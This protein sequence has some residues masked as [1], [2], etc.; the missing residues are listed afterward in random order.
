MELTSRGNRIIKEYRRLNSDAKYRRQSG[1]FVAEGARLCEDAVRSGVVMETALITAR[2]RAQYPQITAA[3]ESAAL[4]AFEISDSM[5]DYLSDTETPQGV[6]G[7]C[8]IPA[9]EGLLKT[10]GRYAAFEQIQDPGNLGTMIRTAEAFGLDGVLLSS[11]CC[12]PYSP[13]VLRSSM[14]GVFRLPLIPVGNLAA[15]LPSLHENGI[16][17]YACVVDNDAMAVQT[18]EFQ[19]GTVCVIGNEGNGLLPETVDACLKRITIPMAG[20]AESLNASMAAGIVFWEMVRGYAY[21]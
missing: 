6:F 5:A 18:V 17:S 10:G 12:D 8:R 14:G 9:F 11:G 13:K 3:V 4:Q 19:G 1:L 20:R 21:E 16:C 7:I 15:Y 2:A